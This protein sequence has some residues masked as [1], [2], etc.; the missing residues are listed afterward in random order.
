MEKLHLFCEVL[1][2]VAHSPNIEKPIL[3]LCSFEA[4]TIYKIYSQKLN[5]LF[6]GLQGFSYPNSK[7]NST[8]IQREEGEPALLNFIGSKAKPTGCTG[9][10]AHFNLCDEG[11]LVKPYFVFQSMLPSTSFTKGIN[12]ITGTYGPNMEYYYMHAKKKMLAGDPNWF[13]F[14]SDFE[15]PWSCQV[16]NA[17]ERA[18][19]K[20]MFDLDDPEQ[21]DIFN[22]E[23]ANIISG[24]LVQFPYKEN[25][26]KAPLADFAVDKAYPVS[27]AWDDGRGVTACWAFQFINGQ[28]YL[29]D[30]VEW[31]RSDMETIS[32]NR[33]KWYMENKFKFGV[34]VMPHT[35]REKTHHFRT[36][37][38]KEAVL[39]QGLKYNGIFLPIPKVDTIT[40]KLEAGNKLLKRSVFHTRAIDGKLTLEKYARKK[41]VSSTGAMAFL[42][43]IERNR[44][45]H[46]GDA[47]GEIALAFVTGRL[48]G[49]YKQLNLSLQ[50]YR[51]IPRSILLP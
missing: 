26:D 24:K 37:A 28:V 27:L 49:A 5:E 15:D 41:Q 36:K 44:F 38:S 8:H 51:N 39:K 47:F 29:F 11:N 45:S 3:N 50:V 17:E 42:D 32:E 43:Q 25:V 2:S 23:Y 33:Y 35:M 9:T 13:A 18:A 30:Y 48:Q 14:K 21:L 7:V 40:T 4:S 31:K 19:I 22:S 6:D 12:I 10:A 1:N 16:F 34:Q 20:S 46:G